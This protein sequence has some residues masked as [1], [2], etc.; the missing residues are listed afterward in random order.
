MPSKIYCN[1]KTIDDIVLA[2]NFF[3][4]RDIFMF[5]ELNKIGQK[6]R[7]DFFE[8]ITQKGMNQF[9]NNNIK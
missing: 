5:E 9:L 2:L 3:L 8:P 4:H 7:N 1:A 6:I